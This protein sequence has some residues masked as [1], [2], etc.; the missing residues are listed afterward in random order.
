MDNMTKT[1][2]LIEELRRDSLTASNIVHDGLNI[3]YDEM[4]STF[5]NEP[6]YDTRTNTI[7]IDFGQ[8]AIIGGRSLDSMTAFVRMVVP[9]SQEPIAELKCM[10][11]G[12]ANMSMDFFEPKETRDAIN[13]L[14]ENIAAK[15]VALFRNSNEAPTQEAAPEETVKEEVPTVEAEVVSEG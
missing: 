10:V 1:K 5:N 8:Y 15:F 3:I 7:V 6:S 9:N 13:T 4:I 14:F 2:E 12:R 11:N